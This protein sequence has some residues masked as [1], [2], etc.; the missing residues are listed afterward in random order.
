[1]TDL[2]AQNL[3]KTEVENT[4]LK[5]FHQVKFPPH[6]INRASNPYRYVYWPDDPD[7]GVGVSFVDPCFTECEDTHGNIV[8][9]QGFFYGFSEKYRRWESNDAHIVSIAN[10]S[11]S[12][13]GRTLSIEQLNPFEGLNEH[14][15]RTKERDGRPYEHILVGWSYDSAETWEV[16][17]NDYTNRA[18]N[19]IYIRKL[20]S[21]CFAL[22]ERVDKECYFTDGV[23]VNRRLGYYSPAYAVS[24]Y[25]SLK[26]HG[27]LDAAMRNFESFVRYHPLDPIVAMCEDVASRRFK[28]IILL[29]DGDP[30]EEEKRAEEEECRREN[31]DEDR[32]DDL[33]D[34]MMRGLIDIYGEPGGWQFNNED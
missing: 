19:Y 29:N 8:E 25:R 15:R 32:N 21:S 20:L 27:L 30:I 18:F 13:L 7:G 9:H 3:E 33:N 22:P 31:A 4:V 23:R 11:D 17:Q 16:A 34:F 26:T 14:W 10:S 2:S 28:D 12:E 1:M 24:L 6:V 5:Y